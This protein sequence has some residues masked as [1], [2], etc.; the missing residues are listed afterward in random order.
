MS[1]KRPDISLKDLEEKGSQPEAEREVRKR[2]L[3]YFKKNK[4]RLRFPERMEKLYSWFVS[5]KLS[6][7]DKA[8]IVG[9][10]LYFLNPLDFVPDLTPYLGF[11]DDIGVISLVFRYLENRALDEKE[12]DERSDI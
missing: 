8:I 11:L 2:F 1:K 4:S 12:P 9:A 3:S 10:L 7:R 5:G 6:R